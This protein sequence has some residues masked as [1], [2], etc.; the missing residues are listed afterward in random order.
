MIVIDTSIFVDYLFDRDEN[1]NE[2]ARKFLNSIEGL[3]VF[4]PKIFVIELISVA[5]RLGI[6][7]SRKDIEEL[8]YD[9]EILS[10]DFVFDEALNVAEKVHPRAADS[11]FIA[12]ARLTNSIL[13][14]SDRLMVRNGKKYG[15]EAYCLL[16]EL[17][18]ALE[19]IGKLKGEG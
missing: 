11:Y 14:S 5:K 18:K 8:T 6:E 16:D 7:I 2:K 10:E 19:A 3:T 4:V 15:I 9:F 13:I 1:R 12:T 17:E